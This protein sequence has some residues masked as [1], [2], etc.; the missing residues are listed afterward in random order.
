MPLLSIN[1]LSELTGKDRRTVK[2]RTSGLKSQPGPKASLLFESKDALE[3]IYF[4][5]P[6]DSDEFVSTPEAVRRLTIRKDAEIALDMEIK[7]KQR[8]PLEICTKVDDEV[9]QSI[10]GILKSRKGKRLDEAAINEIFGMFRDIPA[11]RKW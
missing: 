1:Q 2:T 5:K 4:G 7:S 11:K 9:F 3:A 8:I 10:A 6:G